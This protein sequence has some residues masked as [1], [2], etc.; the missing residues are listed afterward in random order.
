MA[1]KLTFAIL[2][3]GALGGYYGARLHHAGFSVHFVL[4]SDYD[5]VR[6]KGLRVDSVAG[7]FSI[8]SPLVYERIDDLP[9]CDVLAICAKTT[10]NGDF[11]S[12]D[13]QAHL[14]PGGALLILQ[15]GM[16]YE[17][18]FAA[19]FPQ[20]KVFGGMCFLCANR[21]GPGHVSH[22]DYGDI[23][24]ATLPGA[25]EVD[26]SFLQRIA[27][28]FCLAGIKTPVSFEL[29]M[30]RWKKLVW[31][32]PFNG[33]SVLLNSGTDALIA[34]PSSLDMVRSLMEEVVEAARACGTPLPDGIVAN[35]LDSTRRMTP[36]LPSMRLDWD[37]GRPMELEAIYD[38]PMERAHEFGFSMP[39]TQ[40]LRNALKFMQD[41]RGL[42]TQGIRP[43]R[44]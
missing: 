28:A 5:V 2:G 37:N 44:S 26:K 8:A 10:A 36:Y 41:A 4:R 35:Q 9:R 14:K 30:A 3:A 7:D 6:E 43:I 32:I 18:E 39:R 38:R 25:D 1:E 19:R 23:Q 42:L 22:L 24:L 33:L 29:G 11:L 17:E 40:Q 13:L 16:G 34:H 21:L 27:D 12:S 20:A 31:N 15:N